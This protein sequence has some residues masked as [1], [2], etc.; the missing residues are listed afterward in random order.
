MANSQLDIVD[1]VHRIGQGTL[2]LKKSAAQIVN[3]VSHSEQHGRQSKSMTVYSIH[4]PYSPD[5]MHRH[6]YL[7]Q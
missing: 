4:L 1:T 3:S 6:A 5:T 7:E 2:N